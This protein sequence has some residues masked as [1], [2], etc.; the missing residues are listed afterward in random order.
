MNVLTEEKAHLNDLCLPLTKTVS[1]QMPY[2]LE[3]IQA[4]ER[5]SIDAKKLTGG[6]GVITLCSPK[7]TSKVEFA[8][9]WVCQSEDSRFALLEL[10]DRRLEPELGIPQ[11]IVKVI[12]DTTTETI[13]ASEFAV[14][15]QL[16]NLD[17][18]DA[19][20]LSPGAWNARYRQDCQQTFFSS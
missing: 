11:V 8:I 17:T 14:V 4:G 16:M 19:A 1:H 15:L 5:L 10:N 13:S 20:D 2:P 12:D 7:A 3:S 18:S 6:A 9:R